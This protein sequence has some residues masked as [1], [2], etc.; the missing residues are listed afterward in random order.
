MIEVLICAPLIILVLMVFVLVFIV[1]SKALIDE[2]MYID[3]EFPW[4]KRQHLKLS[5]S[6]RSLESA[7]KRLPRVDTSDFDEELDLEEVIRRGQARFIPRYKSVPRIR[8][9]ERGR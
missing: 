7:L 1:I 6:S 2:F 8:Q 9:V 3:L 5:F 4:R